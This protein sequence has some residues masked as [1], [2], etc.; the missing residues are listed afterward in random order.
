MV[1]HMHTVGAMNCTD[2]AFG[3]EFLAAMHGSTRLSSVP[4]SQ[5]EPG[6]LAMV[7]I[8]VIGRADIIR[9]F[10]HFEIALGMADHHA[11]SDAAAPAQDVLGLEHL[12]HRAVPF[13]SSTLAILIC[14]GVS[15]PSGRSGSQTSI[16]DSGMS[17]R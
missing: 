13:H 4:T 3:T 1:E 8:D 14:C 2:L 9:Q 10:A 7:L 5:R 17:I 16:S 11:R 12:V 15:P 6:A